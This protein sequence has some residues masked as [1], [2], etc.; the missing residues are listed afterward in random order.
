MNTPSMPAQQRRQGPLGIA[1]GPL[2]DIGGHLFDRAVNI[3]SLPLKTVLG[4]EHAVTLKNRIVS[5][6]DAILSDAVNLQ[7]LSGGQGR[8]AEFIRL[9]VEKMVINYLKRVPNQIKDELIDDYM[10]GCVKT[11]TADI[12]DNLWPDVEEQILFQLRMKLNKP[13]LTYDS[14]PPNNTIFCCPCL[15]FR[16]CFR[17][18]YMPADMSIWARFRTIWYWLIM[19]IQIIPFYSIQPIF[20]LFT[21]LLLDKGDEYQLI[22]FILDFK[23]LQFFT[24]GCIGGLINYFSYY[25]CV[26]LDN[27]KLKTGAE[28]HRCASRSPTD[29][30]LFILEVVGFG[31]QVFLIWASYLLLFCSIQKGNPIFEIKSEEI[32]KSE[33]DSKF[34]CCRFSRGG[35]IH[36]FM[37][38]EAF[39]TIVSLGMFVVLL[40]P[41]QQDQ[42]S[43]LV[44]TVNLLKVVYGLLSFPF[45]IFAIDFLIKV[46]TRSKPTKYDKFGRC[47]PDLMSVYE[48]KKKEK[49]REAK[50][51]KRKKKMIELKKK[52]PEKYLE[53]EDL[54]DLM[55]F[56]FSEI[57]SWNTSN[58]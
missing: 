40:V 53:E 16:S 11:F 55:N 43:D 22:F 38:W 24:L 42:E 52:N 50:I 18:N 28:V 37:I 9:K 10:C 47:V 21:W 44:A 1:E 46:V 48:K 54:E 57:W 2:K 33:T 45:M 31:L 15:S 19:F 36:Y 56:K 39:S 4:N 51:L 12:I 23:T 32:K 26:V 58:E 13:I 49:K 6:K 17:Y 5:S 35:R 20:K 27:G 30:Y 14:P 7:L 29:F 41:L 8:V 34:G 25:N 3:A